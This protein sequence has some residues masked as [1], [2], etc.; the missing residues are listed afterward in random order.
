MYLY[1]YGVEVNYC[2]IIF[3]KHFSY[4]YLGP[5]DSNGSLEIVKMMGL[6]C[7]AWSILNLAYT[8][9]RTLCY[10]Y[11]IFNGCTLRHCFRNISITH[12][13][14]CGLSDNLALLLLCRYSILMLWSSNKLLM[15]CNKFFLY[16]DA[17]SEQ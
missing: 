17:V 2:F 5:F 3:Y 10:E 12:L 16:S 11:V 4:K 15:S 7:F 8:K 1:A 6:S 9:Y 13:H 14:C